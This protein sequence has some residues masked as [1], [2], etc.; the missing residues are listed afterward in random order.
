MAITVSIDG[1]PVMHDSLRGVSGLFAK[2]LRTVQMLIEEAKRRTNLTV[3]IN[4]TVTPANISQIPFLE[5]MADE[6]RVGLTLTPAVS[7]DIYINAQAAQPFWSKQ[8]PMWTETADRIRA[9]AKRRGTQHLEEASRILAG[10]KRQLPCVFWDRG[11]FVDAD[12]SLYVCPVSSKGRLGALQEGSLGS[13]WRKEI[14]RA[15]LDRLRSTECPDCVSNCMASESDHSDVIRCIRQSQCPIIIFGAGA[16]GRKVYRHLESLGFKPKA[17]V[18][19]SA[20][21]GGT[22]PY[23]IPV[24]P[25]DCGRHCRDAFTI[26]ASSTGAKDI[27]RQLESKGLL[28]GKDFVSYF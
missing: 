14:H 19:N 23:G 15:S 1:G 5:K 2:S 27:A 17:F 11:C 18:D 3:G 6:H 9:Y 8:S 16:G 28:N 26:I 25:W 4:M 13:V 10:A 24:F 12:G 7:S 20:L 22:H 21:E